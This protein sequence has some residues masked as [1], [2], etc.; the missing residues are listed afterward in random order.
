MQSQLPDDETAAAVAAL[1]PEFLARQAGGGLP[2]FQEANSVKGKR[3]DTWESR[4]IDMRMTAD[5]LRSALIP[6]FLKRKTKPGK[7]RSQS[8]T[9]AGKGIKHKSKSKKHRKIKKI[10][11][12]KKLARML[13]AALLVPKPEGVADSAWVKE[14]EMLQN[15]LAELERQNEELK[16]QAVVSAAPTPAPASVAPPPPPPP[17][18]TKA[19][20]PPPPPPMPTGPTKMRSTK[21]MPPPPP[22]PVGPKPQVSSAIK[23]TPLPFSASDL[24]SVLQKR[25]QARS[26]ARAQSP[27]QPATPTLLDS[28][29]MGVKLR[30]SNIDRSP[31]GTPLR[32]PPA[33]AA[34]GLDNELA[35]ALKRRL[36]AMN[37]EMS[38]DEGDSESDWSS[39]EDVTAATDDTTDASE[40]DASFYSCDED[41]EVM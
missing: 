9:K 15:R 35:M 17:M 13:T 21:P 11:S 30:K 29:R 26:H 10:L 19:A 5:D 1:M 12:R 14:Q 2:A 20:A 31:G 33:P 4:M 7:K 36:A 3:K 24:T 34:S 25:S 41:D 6:K 16:K 18:P 40:S 23:R 28:I 38:K 39:D 32:R 22:M 8:K 27:P 37:P